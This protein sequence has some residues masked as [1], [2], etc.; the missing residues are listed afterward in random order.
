MT[1]ARLLMLLLFSILLLPLQAQQK[2]SDADVL[3]DITVVDEK[4]DPLVGATVKDAS[5]SVG[6]VSDMDGKASLWVPR[7]TNLTVSYLGMQSRTVK[8]TKPFKG[9]FALKEDGH[10]LEQVVVNGY[11]QTD[12]RK[13]TG[14]V[15]FLSGKDLNTSSVQNVDML[16]QGKLAGV[17]VQ[18]VSG[19]PGQSAKIRIRGVSS[20]T[21][22]SEPLWVVDGVPLQK[23][24][25]AN[26]N[27]Y[28][29]SGDLTTLYANGVAGI[30]PQDIESINVLKDASASAIYGSQAQAGVIVITTKRG[31]AGKT[32]INYNGS[33]SIQSQPVRDAD[34][35][36][37][38]EKLAY[39]QGIW[40]EF[41]ASG[42]A[43]GG[44]YPVIGVVGEIRSG[45][46]RFAGWTKEQ[47]DAYIA[48]LGQ[49]T[50][51]WF[52]ELFRTTTSQSH[53]VSVSG[54]SDK[55]T[56]YVSGGITTN[57]GIVKRTNSDSYN[58]SMKI[59]GT[60]NDKLMYSAQVDF[61]YLKA[62]APSTFVD[63]FT[64]A[65]FANPYEKPYNDD[66]SYRADDTYYSLASANHS[67]TSVLPPNG[68]N[69]MREI[70][71][72]TQRTKSNSTTLRADLTWHPFKGFRLY[73]LASATFSDDN[74]MTEI[75]ADTYTAWQDRP[76]EG[77]NYY[78]SKRTY[79]SMTQGD[80]KNKSWLTRLQANYSTDIAQLH[81][82]NAI[83]GTEIRYSRAT[84]NTSKVYGWDP[85]IGSHVSPLYYASS[86]DGRLTESELEQYRYLNDNLS[87]Y[88]K[89][90]NAFASFYGAFDYTYN[91]KYVFNATVRSDGNNN[92][93]SKEQFN[94]T[95]STGLAWNIDEEKF[96]KALNPVLTRATVRVSTGLTGGVNKSVYPQVIMN[97]NRS[98][99]R[100]FDNVSYRL[101]YVSNAPN[102]KLRWEHTRD[103]NASLDLGFLHDRISMYLAGYRRKGYDLVTPVTVVTT[104]G[105]TSQSYNTTEQINEGFEVTV[106]GTPIRTN[107][108]SWGISANISY[109]KNYVSKYDK[110][111]S[112][113]FTTVTVDYPQGSIFSGKSTG[114]NPSTG[115]YNYK[116]R[117]DA[118]FSSAESYRDYR[119]YYFYIGTSN[120]PWTGGLST[121]LSYG[122][123][124]LSISSSFSL[125]NKISNQINCPVSYDNNEASVTNRMAILMQDYDVYTA[126]LNKTKGAERRWTVNNP[127]T[128]GNPRLLDAHG[129]NLNLEIDQPYLSNILEAVHYESGSYFKLGSVTLSY[130]LPDKIVRHWGLTGIG[131]NFTANNLFI[132]TGYSGLNPETP[133]AVYPMSRNYSFGINFGI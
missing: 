55:T 1:K 29:R 82:I 19:R 53:N 79:G 65:Y 115:I 6:V 11:T 45:Y 110:L 21:G 46:G 66:G 131:V 60:P 48:E 132:I 104:T 25:P 113:D 117:S 73:G 83:A 7:G 85:K 86:A 111:N 37:S 69:V 130:N 106:N 34:L 100:V 109:N 102:P 63:M 78:S 38:K 15:S 72:T 54:G 126:H 77:L 84:S 81:H 24:I 87:L 51:D 127:I 71:E 99:Y 61:S 3:V 76:Y 16:L 27:S 133:G 49:H 28:I 18:A 39:E 107:K 58:F 44:Y 62:K 41:S 42:Y 128:D 118:D 59:N 80:T 75:G 33:L 64:Y 68:F 43:S 101:A 88:D 93:G 67:V 112:S 90:E 116:A 22:S 14:S 36:N 17:N 103:Y 30:N 97:Y 40:D 121:H 129:T 23:D 125:G 124:S 10:T 4:G 26:G 13:S 123:L 105:F 47:Q 92:F 32:H 114:I 119:N 91:N 70:D 35:M 5:R 12:V 31:K 9:D 2:K 108:F 50:T 20:I 122:N 57:N 89:V 56:F 74:T 8:I 94:L 120:Y 96:F 95:W 52:Q 98:Q